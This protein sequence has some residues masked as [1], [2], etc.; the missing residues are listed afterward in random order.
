MRESWFACGFTEVLKACCVPRR[1]RQPL[2]D[3]W[4]R[5]TGLA[6]ACSQR[7]LPWASRRP[8]PTRDPLPPW[9][10][11]R[12]RHGHPGSVRPRA[13]SPGRAATPH[14]PTRPL[15]PQCT[16]WAASPSCHSLRLTGR[17]VALVHS[18][19]PCPLPPDFR[20]GKDREASG[21]LTPAGR[22][23]SKHPGPAGPCLLRTP[24]SG[25]VLCLRRGAPCR[26]RPAPRS[27]G[28]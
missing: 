25:R 4:S 18:G 3:L 27:R 21:H 10:A 17:L 8:P 20:T 15:T 5:R 22:E 23:P 26:G 24:A 28:L 1:D 9:P 13:V 12:L 14:K 6:S 19:H 16:P 7:T 2:T 11:A